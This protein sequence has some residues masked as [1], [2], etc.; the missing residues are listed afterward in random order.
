MTK[1]YCVSKCGDKRCK[2]CKN[3]IEASSF[4]FNDINLKF[5]IRSD[6]SCNSRNLIYVLF[7]N[8]CNK[9]YVGQTGDEL[10]SRV[11]LHRQHINSPENAPLYV[12]T[13]INQC[14]RQTEPKFHILPIYK[15]KVDDDSKRARIEKQFIQK[16]CPALNC[17][18]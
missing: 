13:H 11:R 9:R 5:E 1:K 15:V 8:G 16:L 3:I 18:R 17:N 2:C 7:C 6:M 12:S 4:Y 14:A 10:R